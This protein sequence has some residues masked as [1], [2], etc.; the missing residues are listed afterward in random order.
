MTVP[1]LTL[2]KDRSVQGELAREKAISHQ[3]KL[4]F[5]LQQKTDVH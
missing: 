4:L 3:L 5:S 2:L 1:Q